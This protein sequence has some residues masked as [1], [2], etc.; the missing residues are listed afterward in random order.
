MVRLQDYFYDTENTAC[1]KNVGPMESLELKKQAS[2][3]LKESLM[4]SNLFDPEVIDNIVAVFE[5][6]AA[7]Y[8]FRKKRQ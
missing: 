8:V 6:V 1:R 3:D 4:E 2:S 5:S 7:D